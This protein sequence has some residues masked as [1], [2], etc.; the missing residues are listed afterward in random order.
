M[1]AIRIHPISLGMSVAFLAVGQD[2]PV[3]VDAGPL[4]Q[5]GR[6]WN[7]LKAAGYQP[8]HL[9]LIVLTHAH[10]DHCGCL[11]PLVEGSGSP[12]AA[13]PLAADRL[14]GE[15]VPLPPARQLWGQI[16]GGVHRLARP[17]MICPA[18]DLQLPLGDG[19]DL[20]SYGLPAAVLHT[21]GHTADSIT[22]LLE[23]GTA[24]VGDLL[25][26]RQGRACPQPYFIEDEPALR[27]SLERL[28]EHRP[29]R[30]YTAH[31]RQP[32]DPPW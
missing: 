2:G 28:R 8:E 3:L 7:A 13:H 27:D 31:C 20:T 29:Q 15:I 6:I 5:E 14:G 26:G 16:M 32:L 23:D 10:P 4:G 22:L 11:P 24:F 30:I 21:P 19:A 18:L 1:P 12:L 17:W 25:V 9:R